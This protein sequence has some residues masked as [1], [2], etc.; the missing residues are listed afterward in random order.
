MTMDEKQKEV[1]W[2][3]K[4]ALLEMEGILERHA[5]DLEGADVLFN[6]LTPSNLDEMKEI[7]ELIEAARNLVGPGGK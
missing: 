3:M 4:K 1:Y 5:E 7:L 2:V 6:K